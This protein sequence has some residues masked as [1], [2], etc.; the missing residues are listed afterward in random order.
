MKVTAAYA[1]A[2]LAELLKAV[3]RGERVTISRY[4][5]PIADLVP[6]ATAQKTPRKF[7]TGKGLKIVL[8]PNWDKP[9]ETEEQLEA[10]FKGE[11]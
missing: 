1:K 11:F 5:T 3:E 7:G 10:F 8:D 9:I 2:N 6:A 4:N